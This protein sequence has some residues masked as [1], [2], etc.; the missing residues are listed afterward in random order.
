MAHP[1]HL[2]GCCFRVLA[3]NGRRPAYRSWED[4]MHVPP[5]GRVKIA[6]LPGDRPGPWMAHTAL[7][8]STTR[9]G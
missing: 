8:S 5:L 9:P 2:H 1:F 3:V 6:R 4:T 7:V